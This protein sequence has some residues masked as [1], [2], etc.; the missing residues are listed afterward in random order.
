MELV[1][2]R[3]GQ[4]FNRDEA[5]KVIRLALLCTNP[6]PAVRPAIS[7]QS[8]A[9]DSETQS[10]ISSP[11]TS[12]TQAPIALEIIDDRRLSFTS[13]RRAEIRMSFRVLPAP[14]C[15][16]LQFIFTYHWI[17]KDVKDKT[18]G[19]QESSNST[20]EKKGRV[21]IEMAQELGRKD[22]N[23][24]TNSCDW[25]SSGTTL[26]PLYEE[27]VRCNCS[28][29]NGRC[30]IVKIVLKGHDLTGVLPRSLAKLHYLTTINLDRNYLSG[31]IP[32]EW[33]STKLEYLIVSANRLSGPIPNYLGSIASLVI[34]SLENNHFSGKVPAE[35]GKLINLEILILSANN[36]TGKLPAELYN[37]KKLRNLELSSNRFDGRMPNFQGLTNL[38]KLELQSSGFEGPI[39]SGISVLNLT[40]LRIGNLKGG[41]DSEFPPL[42]NMIRMKTLMLSSCNI[43]GEIPKFLEN[44]TNLQIL[45]LSFNK[46]KGGI[47]NLRGPALMY[48]TANNLSGPLPEWIKNRGPL[49]QIDLSYN[50]LDKSSLPCSRDTLN[51]FRSYRG[52]NATDLGTCLP[53]CT[54][55]Y[56]SFGVNCGGPTTR[57]GNKVYEEDTG[58]LG[59]QKF[60]YYTRENWGMSSTGFFWDTNTN[61]D[62]SI[63]VAHNQS[64][65]KL[66][67]P[68]LYTTARLSPLSLTYYGRCLANGNYTVTLHFAEIIFRDNQSFQ[69]L[70]RRMF[71]VYIQGERMLEDFDIERE[72]KGVDKAM[73][74]Q[75]KTVVKNTT[76]EIRFHYTGKGTT[77]VPAPGSYG[78][79]ISAILVESDFKPPSDKKKEII[80]FSIGAVVLAALLII[81][82]G[83]VCC[84]RWRNKRTQTSMMSSEKG[85]FTYAQIQVATNNF[86]AENKLGDGGS[87]SVYKGTLSDG[88]VVA[89]KQ[90]SSGSRKGKDLFVTEIGIAAGL[91]HPNLVK[92]YGCCVEGS[93]LL[94]LYEYM[95]N[96]NLGRALYGPEECRLQ[97][98]W[99]TRHNICLGIARGL[100]F[101]HDETALKIVHRDIKAENILLD[102]DLNPKISDFGIA[103]LCE[104]N[105]LITLSDSNRHTHVCGTPGYI[106]PEYLQSGHLTNKVDVYSFG[107]VALEIVS[108]MNHLDYHP[109]PT[110]SCLMEWA[111][112]VGK[113]GNLMELVDPRLGESFNS[114]EVEKVIRLALLCIS[115]DPAV[116]PAISQV[117]S[118]LQLHISI[119]EFNLDPMNCAVDFAIASMINSVLHIA[120][121]LP[122]KGSEKN[123][124]EIPELRDF[125]GGN[126]ADFVA[127]DS[128]RR[129]LPSSSSSRT[130]GGPSFSSCEPDEDSSENHHIDKPSS[131]DSHHY[132]VCRQAFI[133]K[134]GTLLP[135][136]LIS[137]KTTNIFT[138]MIHPQGF[139]WK[140][141]PEETKNI[142]FEEL[143]VQKIK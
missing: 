18:E 117:V 6:D 29:P 73:I 84:F 5:E 21:L 62:N 71:D 53:S 93:Q 75:F 111:I 36:L 64:I 135:S 48:L 4:N 114:D 104:Q 70:G 19:N 134:N 89:V 109:D 132:G 13:T 119:E 141:V 98:N 90:L 133:F 107:I 42:G 140:K 31:T 2:P 7:K 55:E 35:L 139:S 112:V 68:E 34:M 126:G 51:L 8:A 94:V 130:V 28:F 22:W 110:F 127:V 69:S 92:M 47:P 26:N 45:D 120:A 121:T 24:N 14:D 142:Y 66:T 143:K 17:V 58:L 81:I 10:H 100:A 99:P 116:R 32:Q 52:T 60:D 46:L 136:N 23:F 129:P 25:S 30:H 86:S 65:L 61:E 80:Y 115:P 123:R 79:I 124:V 87:A 72:A 101:L 122:V 54:K 15:F 43:Y 38:Q 27:A 44:M 106:A 96:N 91:H 128:G 63:Y 57:I 50:N 137:Q 56:Y 83:L 102:Q 88:T 113:K 77:D 33:A 9:S 138:K 76:I 118:L 40:E 20:L 125:N 108:G 95:Q 1:D 82:L 11:S 41:G 78:S 49:H 131:S 85:F 105:S 59:S 37:L 39:P 103:K 67:E 97:M 12:K 16:E 74:R 3:L